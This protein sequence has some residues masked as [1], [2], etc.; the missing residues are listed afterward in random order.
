MNKKVKRGLKIAIISIASF[1]VLVMAVIALFINFVFTPEK[2]TPVVLK[3]A[4]ETLNAKLEMKSV[5]LT[6][7][8]T[9]PRFGLKL[10]D[11]SLVSKAERDTLFQKKDSLAAFKECVVVVNPIDYLR[12]KKINLYYVGLKDAS[13]YAYINAEGQANWEVVS[14]DTAQVVPTDTVTQ[15]A[16]IA[17]AIDIRRLSLEN[18]DLIFD[19][20]QTNIYGRLDNVNLKLHAS[21]KKGYS[22][23]ALKYSHDNVLFW[24]NGQ[25][26]LNH[27]AAK[28][29]TDMELQRSIRTL[30]L[31]RAVMTVNGTA[32]GVK[33]TL[34]RDTVQHAVDVNLSYGLYVPSVETVIDMIPESI[35]KKEKFEADGKVKVN[36]EIKG[37]YGKDKMPLFSLQINIEDVKAKY[38]RLPY[39]VDNFAVDFNGVVDLMRVQPSFADLKILKFTGA[40][41]DI[42]ANVRAEDLLDDPYITF[43]TNSKIDLTSLAQTFPLQE[44]VSIGGEVEADLRGRCRL[45]TLRNQ[46]IGHIKLGGKL[47]MKDMSLRDSVHNFEFQSN[48]SLAFV[49]DETLGAKAEINQLTLRSKK[50]NSKLENLTATVHSTNP[51]DTTQIASMECRLELDRLR[52][53]IRDSLPAVVF[54]QKAKAVVKLQPQKKNP[55]KPQINLSLETDTLFCSL[56]KTRIGMDKAGFN[57]SAEKLRDSLWLPKGIIGFNH[58]SVRTPEFALPLW[59][60][61]TSLTVGNRE[62]ALRNASLRIGR[63]DM[64]AS[65]SIYDL[66]RSMRRKTPLKADLSIVSRNIDCNQLINSLNF[67]EDTL[68]ADTDTVSTDLKLFVIPK[69]IDFQLR[70]GLKRVVYGKMVFEN[71][72]GAVDVRNQAIHLKNLSM[73]GL[74][75]KMQT[76]LVYRAEEADKGY[77]GFDFNLENVNIGNLVDFIP[78]L[79]SIVPMLRSFKGTVNFNAA[80]ESVI[81][82]ALNIKIPTLR[83]AVHIKGDSLVLMDGETF[84]EISKKLMF[85]NK[86]RNV[87]DSVSVNITVSDGA[88]TVYP[89]LIQ[90]DRYKAAVGGTQGLDMNFDYHISILKSPIPFKLGLNISGTPEKMKFRLGK[91]KYKDDVT[92]VGIH[93]IDSTRLNFGQQIVTNFRQV[94]QRK[95]Q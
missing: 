6:F 33:G 72:N 27:V 39:G 90:I 57:V 44:S 42:L 78:S 1:V 59:F 30:T 55:Q 86:E 49:G 83:A 29:D 87:F 3:T 77:A 38:D 9:F 80:A 35:L 47:D 13:V 84:A 70:T 79:D 67:P 20:R 12:E 69:N 2:L 46:D 51:Q 62:I 68:Q 28:L 66:F 16:P 40:H 63:S 93:K 45:S 53:G 22:A 91:A 17:S 14:S 71:V 48:A 10:T 94:M 31:K 95:S 26:L 50:I 21:L 15:A 4:N 23:L 58:L 54:C 34:K 82:S 41:T 61:K 73:T 89:F 37:L 56:D 64:T 32:F 11:G 88:V 24:Q 52:G 36:G 25:L 75:A 60:S 76:T 7:F 18:A 43:S 5:E 85:K 8:S 19:D 92:P 74:G 81:D 65:G